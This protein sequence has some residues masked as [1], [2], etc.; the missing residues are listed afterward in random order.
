MFGRSEAWPGFARRPRS[1]G[2]SGPD[3]WPANQRGSA[4]SHGSM[5]VGAGL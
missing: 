4:M 3:P 2:A 1:P 5:L